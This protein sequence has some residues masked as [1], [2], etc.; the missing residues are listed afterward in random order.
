M[1]TND[2]TTRADTI[3]RGWMAYTKAAKE[4]L[5]VSP[6]I[7]REAIYSGALPAYQKPVTR[8]RQ[9][10]RPIVFVSLADVDEW[11]RSTWTPATREGLQ[12]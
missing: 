7:L 11:I 8:G 4:Y 6:D 1:A 10:G 3:P 2:C 9:D 5:H 12:R